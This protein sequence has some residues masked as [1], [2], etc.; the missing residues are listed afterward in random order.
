MYKMGIIES[1]ENKIASIYD[2]PQFKF[3]KTYCDKR[4]TKQDLNNNLSF[5]MEKIRSEYGSIK[6]W[7][8]DKF[9]IM[10]ECINVVKSSKYNMTLKLNKIKLIGI[11]DFDFSFQLRNEETNVKYQLHEYSHSYYQDI[12]SVK[13]KISNEQPYIFHHSSNIRTYFK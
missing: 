13:M 11:R 10:E 9:N 6:L 8:R 7:S 12:N 1:N 5:D 4:F 3:R 2:L